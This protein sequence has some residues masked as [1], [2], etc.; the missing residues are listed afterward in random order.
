MQVASAVSLLL[1][2]SAITAKAVYRFAQAHIAAQQVVSG[3]KVKILVLA[4][5]QEISGLGI[6]YAGYQGTLDSDSVGELL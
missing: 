6:M 4:V 2:L 3:P 1:T 5:Q